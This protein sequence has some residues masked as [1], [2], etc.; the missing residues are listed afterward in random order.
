MRE[1]L[2][3]LSLAFSMLH[4]ANL[5]A[6]YQKAESNGLDVHY[7]IFGTGEPLLIIGGGPGDDSGRYLSL[8]EVLSENNQCILV[9]QRGT[10]KSLP[11]VID[12]STI[13]VAL[14]LEDF[15]AVRQKC[16]LN[17]WNILGFSYGGFIASLYA[18]FYPESVS[19]M[20][21]LGSAGLNTSF[22]GHFRDNVFSRMQA[23]DKDKY[24]YWADS[25]RYAQQ[26]NHALAEIV[27]AMIPGYF[28]D[29]KKSLLVSEAI[30]D[31]DFDQNGMGKLIWADIQNNNLDLTTME[32]TF[33]GSV[34][35]LHGRQDPLGESVALSLSNYYTDSKL[36][37]V[38]QAGHYSWIEQP[39][40]IRKN[41]DEFIE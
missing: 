15:E 35:V 30:K 28:Y 7:R 40:K 14:T 8:C 9:D 32:Q 38:E 18:H 41:I 25:T 4:T 33:K 2:F 19:S 31:T 36:V 10:G 11:A 3:L 29:R 27:R 23:G 5:S 17:K 1:C 22:F 13:S 26:P 21:L 20:V 12:S 34:L 16:G 6:Q 24:E 37:F 39:E